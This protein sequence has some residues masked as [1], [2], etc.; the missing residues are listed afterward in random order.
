MNRI[1]KGSRISVWV[2]RDWAG[3][4]IFWTKPEKINNGNPQDEWNG[5][6]T[7]LEHVVVVKN[8]VY[9]YT[10]NWDINHDPK[11]ITIELKIV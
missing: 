3:S 6:L 10:Y 5:T 11:K 4:H 9:D 2:C 1:S 7:G 8:M